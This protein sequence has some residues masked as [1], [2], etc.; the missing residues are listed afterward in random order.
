MKQVFEFVTCP[1]CGAEPLLDSLR[2]IW[3]SQQEY[4]KP[5]R[6]EFIEGPMK[7]TGNMEICS[8]CGCVFARSVEISNIPLTESIDKEETEH[9][10]KMG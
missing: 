7:G 10:E 9:G 3:D 8:K 2:K 5:M 6:F 4:P 1:A